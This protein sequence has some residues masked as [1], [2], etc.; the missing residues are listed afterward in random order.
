MHAKGFGIKLI[1]KAFAR[2]YDLVDAIHISMVNA[3][4]V[5]CVWDGRCR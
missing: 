2:L 3:V 1:D 5:Q 4:K